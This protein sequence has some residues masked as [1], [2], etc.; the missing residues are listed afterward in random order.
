M[1]CIQERITKDG[2]KRSRV[3]INVKGYPMQS[4]TFSSKTKAQQWGTKVETELHEGKYFQ[5]SEARKHTLSEVIDRYI[6]DVMPLKMRSKQGGI[7]L[8]WK[9]ELGNYSLDRITPALIAQKRDQL[10]REE[11]S[12]SKK[13]APA[14]VVRY[15]ATLS[16]VF[17]IA[18]KEYNWM[19]NS[20]LEKVSKPKVNNA[21]NRFLSDDERKRL[22]TACKNSNNKMLYTIVVIA[23]GTGMR[24]SEI[25]T[26]KWTNINLETGIIFLTNTKNKKPRKAY[27]KGFVWEV[28]KN[29]SA[30]NTH[31]GYVFPSHNGLEPIDIRA[32]WEKVLKEAKIENMKFHDLRHTF[33]SYLTMNKATAMETSILLGHEDLSMTRRY[34]H[35]GDDHAGETVKQMIDN[36]F[37]DEHE[38]L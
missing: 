31:N 25:L 4:A 12:P 13:R 14:T 33:A 34:S 6:Q 35:I 38:I 32:P 17:T 21:R 19:E 37:R 26:L 27:L 8:W 3:Q 1:V 5:A 15:L 36:V 29:Y 2:K 18:I 23:I 24:K 20:P 7:L 10:L 11:I 16:H 28:F 30:T 22:L 9:K